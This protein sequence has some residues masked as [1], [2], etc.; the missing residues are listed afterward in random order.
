M[1]YTN[2]KFKSWREVRQFIK[3]AKKKGYMWASRDAHRFPVRMLK[4]NQV[5]LQ[6]GSLNLWY[7]GTITFDN[8]ET[9]ET[10]PYVKGELPYPA[11]GDN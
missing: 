9:E 8:L 4:R 10:I 6:F 7:D 5:T 1:N 11:R 3:E 2:Y